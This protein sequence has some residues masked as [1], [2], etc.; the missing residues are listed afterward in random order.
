MLF[1][2]DCVRAARDDT[3]SPPTLLLGWYSYGSMITSH[4]PDL[5]VVLDEFESQ[6]AES[7]EAEIRLRAKE[8][9]QQFINLNEAQQQELAS[10]P[11]GRH[12]LQIPSSPTQSVA[13]GGIESVCSTHRVSRESSRM[14]FDLDGVR[15]S[16]HRIRHKTEQRESSARP[17][18]SDDL[19]IPK[20]H[21]PDAHICYLLVSP[22]LPPIAAITTMFSKLSFTPKSAKKSPLPADADHELLTHLTCV[23]YGD[24]DIFTSHSKLRRWVEG[25]VRSSTSK[26]TFF[27]I[28]DTGHFWHEEGSEGKLKK[29]ITEWIGKVDDLH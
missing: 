3:S 9:S 12:S 8:L 7:P 17:I 19:D 28:A 10:A 15:R 22:L 21:L 18:S 4:L 2:L 20:E 13:I 23:V 24:S 26:F 11:S 6:P 27:E 5:Q 14:S 16:I 1:Y 25:C 29:A